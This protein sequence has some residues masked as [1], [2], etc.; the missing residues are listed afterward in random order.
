MS[1]KNRLGLG[2]SVVM[3]WKCTQSGLG[4]VASEEYMGLVVPGSEVENTFCGSF[5]PVSCQC[6]R[7]AHSKKVRIGGGRSNSNSVSLSVGRAKTI[8]LLDEEKNR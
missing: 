5:A 3:F 7:D 8:D 4:F 6:F 2:E 1:L